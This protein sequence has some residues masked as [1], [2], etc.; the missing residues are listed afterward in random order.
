MQRLEQSLNTSDRHIHAVKS[1]KEFNLLDSVR[2]CTVK[3]SM[4]VLCYM[5]KSDE[6]RDYTFNLTEWLD[7][8]E[9][10][11]SAIGSSCGSS[12]FI[13]FMSFTETC[14]KAHIFG[15]DKTRSLI[16]LF[17]ETNKTRIKQIDFNISGEK[18]PKIPVLVAYT[19]NMIELNA[20]DV[21]E[22]KDLWEYPKDLIISHG[23][24]IKI[25]IKNIGDNINYI[26]SIKIIPENSG[27][28]QKN[29]GNYR[30]NSSDALEIAVSNDTTLIS[31]AKLVIDV[32]DEKPIEINLNSN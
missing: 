31:I 12:A 8:D 30:L 9:Y 19:A 2:I 4:G 20:I 10:I 6:I 13:T 15:G 17:V 28:S 14:V 21:I 23:E 16:S 1:E 7:K 32:G 29:K 25:N 27:F 26:N 22:S 18:F 11:K 3:D 5:K 24:T